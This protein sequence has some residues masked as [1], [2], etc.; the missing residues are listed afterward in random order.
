MEVEVIA[1]LET[2]QQAL[3]VFQFYAA[4][5]IP[6][7]IIALIAALATYRKTY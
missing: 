7:S 2:I 3:I 4:L 5:F 1:L 6:V